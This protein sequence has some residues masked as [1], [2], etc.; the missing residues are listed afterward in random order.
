[1][2]KTSDSLTTASQQE[3]CRLIHQPL[4][5]VN[6]GVVCLPVGQQSLITAIR[7][8]RRE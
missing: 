6:R 4:A 8:T 2:P 1:M 3:L 5:I 7:A